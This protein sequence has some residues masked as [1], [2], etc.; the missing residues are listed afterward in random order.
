MRTAVSQ[1]VE[2]IHRAYLNQ[3]GTYPP[4]VR[5]GMPLINSGTVHVAAAATKNLHL[6]ATA[7]SLGPV[8]G[9][10]VEWAGE[11][12]GLAWTLRFF[13]PVV[14][15]PLGL[16]D[17]SDGPAQAEVRRELGVSTV[18][19]HVLAQPGSGLSSH[20]AAHVGTSLAGRDSATAR[21]FETIRH[22]ARGAENLVDELIG[23]TAAGLP[24]A[25]ALLAAAVRP[26]DGALA[27][28][29]RQRQPDPV[30][31]RRALLASVGATG[32]E[33]GGSSSGSTQ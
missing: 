30:A 27:E 6:L 28:L 26:Y 4:A 7:E 13:D 15:P 24:R 5:G 29:S 19:Y 14:L 16:I 33:E 10:E 20:H 9:Q 32:A 12:D 11:C 2:G 31:V 1:Y 17:E 8:Q 21:D 22:R 25:Q 18:L 3:A 23:A